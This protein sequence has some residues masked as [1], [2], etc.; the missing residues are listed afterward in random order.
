MSPEN[1]FKRCLGTGDLVM[2]DI[3]PTD[4]INMLRVIRSGTFLGGIK[5]DSA[6]PDPSMEVLHLD[7][8]VGGPE[9]YWFKW[10][11]K[12]RAGKN[13]LLP[14]IWINTRN[15]TEFHAWMS[16]FLRTIHA[17]RKNVKF[18]HNCFAREAR[19]FGEWLACPKCISAKTALPEGSYASFTVPSIPEPAAT[20]DPATPIAT[21]NA[22]LRDAMH[23][24][25]HGKCQICYREVAR[26]NGM[27][28][29]HIFP[30]SKPIGR[31]RLDLLSQGMPPSE[32]DLFVNRH[33]HGT[34]DCVLNY[35]LLCV[36]CNLKK[37]NDVLDAGALSLRFGYTAKHAVEIVRYVNARSR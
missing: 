37:T 22:H 7:M 34:H 3:D 30:V 16:Q 11:L 5:P 17:V 13:L 24:A 1:F 27:E 26:V 35:T 36:D 23:K 10:R 19:G 8:G 14:K 31:I 4:P 33:W 32:A 21:T 12:V 29:D 25:F 6:S 9:Y 20:V 15:A 18:A 2:L 28:I